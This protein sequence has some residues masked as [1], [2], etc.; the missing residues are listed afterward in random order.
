MNRKLFFYR[1]F[2]HTENRVRDRSD[3]TISLFTAVVCV[4][5]PVLSDANNFLFLP[6]GIEKIDGR[7][8]SINIDDTIL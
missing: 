5:G 2:D 3:S 7:Y 6:A 4:H 8:E 1:A